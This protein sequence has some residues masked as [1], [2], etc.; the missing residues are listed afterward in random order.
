[1]VNIEILMA[2]KLFTNLKVSPTYLQGIEAKST[3][4][5]RLKSTKEA[6]TSLALPSM[7]ER[8]FSLSSRHLS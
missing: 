8:V 4:D 2:I 3:E 6:E 1:V 7:S 5:L